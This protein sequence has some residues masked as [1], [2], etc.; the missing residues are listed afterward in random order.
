MSEK[1]QKKTKDEIIEL[2]IVIMLGITALM[3]AWA[4]WVSSLH[5]SDQAQN[6]TTSNNLAAEGNSE[7]N[8]AIQT[9]TQDMMLY[10][11]INSLMI[12]LHF[13]VTKGDMDEA[14]KIEWKIDEL[15]AGNMSEELAEAFSWAMD[16]AQR[17]GESVSPFD[18]EGFI[19]SYFEIANE[20]L[21][22]SEVLLQM[23]NADND[24]SSAYALATVIF[25]VV[26]F[27]LGVA[28]TFK[29]E[30]NK[31]AVIMIAGVAFI[32]ATVYMLTVPMPRD[33]N[34]LKFFGN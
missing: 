24:N 21:K 25:S 17:L 33:F 8:A 28:G 5:G 14:E 1:K 27:L 9:L 23:G 16:E 31:K 10:N 30:R 20:L 6:Y 7:Y 3:V 2:I 32:L 22:E 4:S 19:E 11:E 15:T 34:L 29:N 18:K 26:L 12:D 13:S